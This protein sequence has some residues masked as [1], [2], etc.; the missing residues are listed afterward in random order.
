MIL[1]NNRCDQQQLSPKTADSTLE[2]ELLPLLLLLNVFLFGGVTVA[3][4]MHLFPSAI[5]EII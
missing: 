3:A 4:S 2:A 1:E 5:S